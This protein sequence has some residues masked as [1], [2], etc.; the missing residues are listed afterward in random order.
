MCTYFVKNMFFKL[1]LKSN[2]GHFDSKVCMLHYSDI[3]LNTFAIS[4][5]YFIIISTYGQDRNK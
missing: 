5:P 3:K 4:L 1:S 2:D